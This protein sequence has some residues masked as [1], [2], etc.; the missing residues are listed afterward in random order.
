MYRVVVKLLIF[1]LCF[2][3]AAS[4]VLAQSRENHLYRSPTI[5]ASDIAFLYANDIWMVARTGEVAHRLTS[6]ADVHG[7]IFF[8]PRWRTIAYQAG[9]LNC[10][11]TIPASG[12]APSQTT[13]YPSSSRLAG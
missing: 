8:S 1:G 7:R 9:V 5:S 2:L 6:T 4:P 10:V 11:S 13:Y 3:A 12:G